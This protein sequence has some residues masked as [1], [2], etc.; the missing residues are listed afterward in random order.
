MAYNG[1]LN[2]V[3]P[4]LSSYDLCNAI[5]KLEVE[6]MAGLFSSENAEN[7]ISLDRT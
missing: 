2:I 3:A 7:Q 1:Y 4:Y 6:R 5:E